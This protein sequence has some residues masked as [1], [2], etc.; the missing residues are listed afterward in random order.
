MLK[1]ECGHCFNVI[2]NPSYSTNSVINGVK[3]Y[4]CSFAH[5]V[6]WYQQYKFYDYCRHITSSTAKLDDYCQQCN[7]KIH[8]P[9]EYGILSRL[10][11]VIYTF[12]SIECRT[13]FREVFKEHG[14][15]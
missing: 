13:K 2:K 15:N 11:Y 10:Y 7:I 4:F 3:Y 14:T 5:F 1:I 8:S 12:C 6:C 9:R